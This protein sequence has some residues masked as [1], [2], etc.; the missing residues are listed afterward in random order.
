MLS[1]PGGDDHVLGPAH[2][3]LRS[4][5]QRL[6]RAAALPVDADRRDAVGEV[7]RHHHVAADVE[8]LLADLADAAGN[9]VLDR[10][11]IDPASLDQRIE[12]GG[13]EIGRMPVAQ[14]PAAPP[15]RRAQR[16]DDI[17]FGHQL[18]LGSVDQ[19]RTKIPSL[20]K[21]LAAWSSIRA[22]SPGLIP[23]AAASI[24]SS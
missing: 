10:R 12:H 11:G 18:L 1:T 16:L 2:H 20:L 6:L 22:H 24:G 15:T 17:S 21:F 13:A 7:G 23:P 4:E 3:R 19:A 8:A 14:G 5:M 9:H